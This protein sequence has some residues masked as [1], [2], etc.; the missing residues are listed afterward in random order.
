M[1]EYR[2][3]GPFFFFFY[4]RTE[5]TTFAPSKIGVVAQMVRA[6]DS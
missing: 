5:L 1:Q 4:L 6:S 2:I 3:I